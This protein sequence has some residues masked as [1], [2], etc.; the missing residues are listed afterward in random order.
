[1]SNLI[2]QVL[3]LDSE[4]PLIDLKELG[5]F[6]M[7]TAFSTTHCLLSDMKLTLIMVS[8]FDI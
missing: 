8:Y 2:R 1:M 3:M 4:V 7:Y 5:V 6:K